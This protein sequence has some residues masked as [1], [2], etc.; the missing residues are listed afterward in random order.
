MIFQTGRINLKV[1]R[2]AVNLGPEAH[3][4]LQLESLPK[5]EFDQGSPRNSTSL[6][7]CVSGPG[8]RRAKVASAASS[9]SPSF[10]ASDDEDS[11]EDDEEDV[12]ADRSAK[13]LLQ[14]F[15]EE[16]PGEGPTSS[17]VRRVLTT[18]ALVLV[19]IVSDAGRTL[20]LQK[21]LSTTVV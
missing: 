20:I 10:R 13:P 8:Q 16:G 18:Y 6:A 4:A 17:V 3:P 21:S 15:Q 5:S 19:Y 14:F 1:I 2:K 9:G 11:A 12:D 7:S